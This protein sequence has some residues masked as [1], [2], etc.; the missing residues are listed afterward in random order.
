MGEINRRYFDA[1]MAGKRLSLRKLAGELGM[2]HSQLSLTFNGARRMQID[3][4]A[5]MSNIFGVPL[6][7]IV[8]AAGVMVRPVSGRR[9]RVVGAMR[10]DGTVDVY[11]P[12]VIEM[13]SAPGDLPDDAVAIQARSSGSPLDWVDGVVM[14]CRQ[15]DG[16][17]PTSLG[18]LCWVKVKDGPSAVAAVKRGY[19]EGTFN[20][21]GP[22]NRES[23]VLEWASPILISRN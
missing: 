14:F 18:R 16:V 13:A 21:S 17:A 8:E 7:E 4:A 19:Q 20:L 10:G 22:Y 6:H 5:A 1:L 15:P 9:V 12:D 23:A 2:N 11:G 3:E